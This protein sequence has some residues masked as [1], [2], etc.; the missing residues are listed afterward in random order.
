VRVLLSGTAICCG[1]WPLHLPHLLGG[2]RQNY[3]ITSLRESDALDR[4][5]Q[6][7]WWLTEGNKESTRW[8]GMCHVGARSHELLV[9]CFHVYR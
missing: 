3:T 8:S 5:E 9:L 4:M 2:M 6:L 7:P 1:F